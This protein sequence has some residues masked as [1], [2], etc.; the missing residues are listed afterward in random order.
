MVRIDVDNLLIEFGDPV[1]LIIDNHRCNN[2]HNNNT[3]KHHR[4][5][6]IYKWPWANPRNGRGVNFEFSNL[7][8]PFLSFVRK[9]SIGRFLNNTKL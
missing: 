8:T 7:S 4:T 1:H 2:N 5:Y 9:I 3:N 6:L